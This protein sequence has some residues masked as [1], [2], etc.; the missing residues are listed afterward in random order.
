MSQFNNPLEIYKLLPKTNCRQCQLR[1]CLSFADAVIKG[2]KKI[3]DC[4]HLD[5]NTFKQLDGKIVQKT[6]TIQLQQDE[7]LEQMKKQ[8]ATI[9]LS[10]SAE[11]LGATYSSGKLAIKVLGRNFFIDSHGNITSECHINPWVTVPL[12]SYIITSKG[13]EPSGKWV[14]FRELKNGAIRQPLFEQRCEKPLKEIADQ[15]KEFFESVLTIFGG[16]PVNNGFSSDISLV[17]YPIP[18]LPIVYNYS[19]FE[20]GM[21]SSFNMFFDI[22]AEDNL[23]IESIHMICT[24]ITSMFEKISQRHG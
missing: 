23:H 10:S 13:T 20:E 22:N 8:V 4:P 12:L 1:T 3:N 16:K 6:N 17:L 2:Q 11:R 7:L 19:A 24:G 9:D 18:K 14:P 5:S 15:S 21:G